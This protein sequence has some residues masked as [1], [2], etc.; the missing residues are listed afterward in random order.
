M[1]YSKK[2]GTTVSTAIKHESINIPVNSD[3]RA[4]A[5]R[6]RY[7]GYYTRPSMLPG[8]YCRVMGDGFSF[9]LYRGR[10]E[11]KRGSS[12]AVV[13]ALKLSGVEL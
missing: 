12:T 8:C 2:G 4:I 6:L 10:V 13:E 3:L 11:V 7:H 9:L 5:R 1:P